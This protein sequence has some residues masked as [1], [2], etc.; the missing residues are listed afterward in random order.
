MISKFHKISI[1]NKYPGNALSGPNTVLLIDGVEMK[2]VKSFSFEIDARSLATAKI[3][4]YADV[5]I[6]EMEFGIGQM[7]MFKDPKK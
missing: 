2:G 6:D 1:K 5:D 7:R 4:M 3:E